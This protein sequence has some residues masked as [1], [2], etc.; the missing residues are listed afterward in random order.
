MEQNLG[1]MASSCWIATSESTSTDIV[2]LGWET[3]EKSRVSVDEDAFS[4]RSFGGV[5][6]IGRETEVAGGPA[7]SEVGA[8]GVGGKPI[9]PASSEELP[10][11][12]S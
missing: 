2:G 4:W 9:A 7:A 6:E 8:T 12:N 11:G 1:G 5:S 3:A 10:Q